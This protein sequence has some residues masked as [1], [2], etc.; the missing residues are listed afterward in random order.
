M[1][2]RRHHSNTELVAQGVANIASPLFGGIPATGAIARTA[3]NI[4]NNA[5]TPVSG[6]VHA[7][8]LLLVMLF[9]GRWAALVPMAALGGIVAVVAYNMSEWRLF[10]KLVKSTK[11]D[12]GVM[13]ATFALTVLADLT[14]A[15]QT[16]VILAAFLF[17]RRVA[18]TAKA[19]YVTRLVK[20][21]GDD[22]PPAADDTMG[23]AA[24][25]VPAGV[26]V[27]EV[28]GPMFFGA[29]ELFKDTLALINVRPRV[30]VIRMRYAHSLD[31][32]ALHALEQVHAEVAADGATLLLSGV[33]PQPRAVLERSGL[34]AKIG[35]ANMCGNL[36]EAL[37]RAAEII[38]QR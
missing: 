17:V 27:F 34:A 30:L 13:L 25:D 26:E 36:D 22:G 28:E 11:S 15:I 7:V 33:H 16:G 19:G 3:T 38:S 8:F 9:L 2:G 10:V 14:V 4:R 23:V 1:T 24:R 18:G 20:T 32:T 5:A 29:A 37:A 12:A 31:A 6:L 21:F 35:A